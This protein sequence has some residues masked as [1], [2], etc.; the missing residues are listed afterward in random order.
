MITKHLG[1][2]FCSQNMKLPINLG[3]VQTS[4]FTFAESKANDE[5]VTGTSDISS[6]RKLP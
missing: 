1:W 3:P 5:R 4:Q 2:C 6:G